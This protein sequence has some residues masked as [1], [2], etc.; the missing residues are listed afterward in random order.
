VAGSCEQVNKP[1]GSIRGGE[2]IEQLNHYQ[3]VKN[4]AP[5]SFIENI[6]EV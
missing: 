1:S 4:F 5:W 6:T 2:Y 3:L